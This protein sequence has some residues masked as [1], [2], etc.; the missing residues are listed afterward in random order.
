MMGGLGSEACLGWPQWLAE[1]KSVPHRRNGWCTGWEAGWSQGCWEGGSV[2][3]GEKGRS[4]GWG[5]NQEARLELGL[6]LRIWPLLSAMEIFQ[7]LDS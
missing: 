6:R 7:D 5:H 4:R 1:V 2:A 3:H